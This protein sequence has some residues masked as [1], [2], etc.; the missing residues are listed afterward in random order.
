MTTTFTQEDLIRFIYHETSGNET[1]QIQNAIENDWELNEEYQ[2][3]L[4]TYRLLG[5]ANLNPGKNC[6]DAILNH[7]RKTGIVLN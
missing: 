1:E 5:K 4:Q 6:L 2:S 3:L 7:S